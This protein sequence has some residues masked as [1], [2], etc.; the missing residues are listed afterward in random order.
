MEATVIRHEN[1]GK[2]GILTEG[3]LVWAVDSTGST[4]QTIIERFTKSRESVVVRSLNG[5]VLL[6]VPLYR[7]Y[8]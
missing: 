3:S 7:I 2:R 6:R 4:H 1:S 8:L 5:E